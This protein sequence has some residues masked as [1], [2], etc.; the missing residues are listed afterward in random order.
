MGFIVREVLSRQ[1]I[2]STKVADPSG[3][4]HRTDSILIYARSLE[5]V[6]WALGRLAEY[7]KSHRDHF[8]LDLPAAA[9]FVEFR[10][11]FRALLAADGVDPEPPGRLARHP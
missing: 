3:L 11:S 2:G 6:D 5:D 4:E 9:D 1:G 10:A 7:Q 8:L